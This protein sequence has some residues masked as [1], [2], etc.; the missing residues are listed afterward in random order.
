MR[1]YPLQLLQ[2]GQTAKKAVVLLLAGAGIWWML[3]FT[4]SELLFLILLAAIQ[5][6]GS[7]VYKRI[8]YRSPASLDL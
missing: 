4:M 7:L 3:S 1:S 8:T 2:N 6:T 5:Q